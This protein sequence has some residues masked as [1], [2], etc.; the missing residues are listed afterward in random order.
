MTLAENR[1]RF[2][3]AVGD[4]AAGHG[5]V[6]KGVEHLRGRFRGLGACVVDLLGR[7]HGHDLQQ[8]VDVK[9]PVLRLDQLPG[10]GKIHKTVNPFGH[11]RIHRI[12]SPLYSISII[13]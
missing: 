5:G 8:P 7:V 9:A 2:F 10:D 13:Q 1:S 4:Q 6:G 11:M 12:T 3:T